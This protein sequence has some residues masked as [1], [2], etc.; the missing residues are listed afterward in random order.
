MLNTCFPSLCAVAV[1]LT[2]LISVS[3]ITER[4]DQTNFSCQSKQAPGETINT[5]K[6]ST[7]LGPEYSRAKNYH[8]Y[9]TV[10]TYS[11]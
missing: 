8:T 2:V 1:E 3:V 4:T 7:N 5:N 11:C 6:G 10:H 9:S